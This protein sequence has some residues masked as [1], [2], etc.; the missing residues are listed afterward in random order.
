[1]KSLAA[2]TIIDDAPWGI[3]GVYK[4]SRNNLS[5]D[6]KKKKH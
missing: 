6:K 4:I 3:G 5:L 1:M 2:E